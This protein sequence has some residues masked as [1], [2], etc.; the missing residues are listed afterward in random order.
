[1]AK[2]TETTKEKK[3][4]RNKKILSRYNELKE[5][6]TC[7]EAQTLLQDEFDL[8]EST[9]KNILFIK[10]YSNS[11]IATNVATTVATK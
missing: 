4:R 7:R 11:P 2:R 10:S 9:I 3:L 6:M 5:V 8:A 1:M